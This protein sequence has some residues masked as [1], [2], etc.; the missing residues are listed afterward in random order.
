MRQRI[1]N[2]CR[3][4]DYPQPAIEALLQGWNAVEA[5]PSAQKQ[6]LTLLNDY[7]TD[8]VEDYSKLIHA[9][10]DCGDLCGISG[11]TTVFL[12][13]AC[14]TDHAHTLYR[15]QGISD[16]IFHDTFSDLKWK[17]L[18]CKKVK[19]VWG[20]FVAGWYP[21][22]YQLTRFAL[23]RLQF[24][25]I[26]CPFS[27]EKNGKTVQEGE[28]A[29]NVH[30]PSCGPLDHTLCIDSYRKAASFY[31]K[32]FNGRPIVFFCHSWLLYPRHYDFLPGNSRILTFMK[33]YDIVEFKESTGGDLWRIFGQE[34]CP[35]N[36][37][38]LPADTSLQRAYLSWLKQGNAPG[39]GKGIFFWEGSV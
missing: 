21:R 1:E 19:D 36:L 26:P 6:F 39:S 33:D 17:L 20:T 23:G 14:M 31:Q 9:G 15:K 4:F 22:F 30:I 12:L 37:N 34:Y 38:K 2:F 7:E 10:T 11:Y 35:E 29:L 32:E 27:Y 16:E 8:R 5:S 13:L 24:E 18:E 25:T 3:E 28:T